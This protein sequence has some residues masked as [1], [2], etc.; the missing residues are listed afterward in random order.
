MLAVFQPRP[1]HSTNAN[2]RIISQLTTIPS[3]SDDE[4]RRGPFKEARRNLARFLRHARRQCTRRTIDNSANTAAALLHPRLDLPL[5]RPLPDDPLLARRLLCSRQLAPPHASRGRPPAAVPPAAA[6]WRL[7]GR[8]R[9][10]PEVGSRRPAGEARG[11]VAGAGGDQ[12]SDL[13]E[14]HD[15]VDILIRLRFLTD[16]GYDLCCA[17]IDALCGPF[18]HCLAHLV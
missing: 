6:L 18:P 17:R 1:N 5:L 10:G 14:L 3:R 4:G 8:Q 16:F 15:T 11:V 13:W 7:W 12:Y 9:R 2:H